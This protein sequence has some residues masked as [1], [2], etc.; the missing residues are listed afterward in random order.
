MTIHLIIEGKVQGVFFRASTKD[1]ADRLGITGWVKNTFDGNVE[2]MA[3]G[4]KNLIAQFTEWCK[5]G[6]RRAL[7][8]NISITEKDEIEFEEF[9]VLRT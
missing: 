5:H 3:S 8:T 4:R 7:V 2:I 1:E 6:P 9:S